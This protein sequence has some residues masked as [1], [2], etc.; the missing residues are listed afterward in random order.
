MRFLKYLALSILLFVSFAC[1]KEEKNPTPADGPKVKFVVKIDGEQQRLDNLGQPSQIPAGHAAQTPSFNGIAAHYIELSQSAFTAV[2]HGAIIYHAPEVEEGGPLAVDFDQTKVV[3]DGEVI[4][5]MPLHQF[6]AG[7]Y[8]FAR[9]SIVYQNY[10]VSFT[11]MGMNMQSTI[12]SFVGFNTFIRSHKVRQLTDVVNGNRMQGYWA[13]ET[14]PNG[15]LTEPQLQTGQSAGTTVPNPIAG[16]SPIPP[17]SCLVTGAFA[18]RLEISGN[19]TED[20]IIELSFSVNNSF[21]WKD[22][23]GNGLFEPLEDE[24]VV[25]MG[26]RGLIAKRVQ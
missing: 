5:E 7:K 26:L 9:V 3:K 21:E 23:N 20:V 19:E 6:P 22:D 14:H 1:R 25:D 8:E 18:E 15:V 16:T 10:D 17:G 2:G 11:A 24:Q 12:A 4:F 13:W